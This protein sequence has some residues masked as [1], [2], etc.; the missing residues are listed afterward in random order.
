[1]ILR[2]RVVEILGNNRVV[3]E[4]YK[5]HDEIKQASMTIN[6]TQGYMGS[7]DEQVAEAMALDEREWE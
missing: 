3:I 7:T 2:C 4:P 5:S 1:M 6:A